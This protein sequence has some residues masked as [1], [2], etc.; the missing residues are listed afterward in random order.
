LNLGGVGKAFYIFFLLGTVM[1]IAN[2]EHTIR[3]SPGEQR[4]KIR[5]LVLG[6]GGLFVFFVFTSSQTLLFSQLNL[7]MLPVNSFVFLVCTILI[8]YS[9]VRHRLM[10]VN[11][12]MSR[13]IVYNSLTILVV[14]GYLIFVGLVTQ[15]VRSFD[16]LPG[17]H[18]E[19]LFLFLAIVVL[20]GLFL[21]DRI[22]WKARMFI[23]KHFYRS[24]YDYRE[25]WL[26][27]SEGLSL[28]LDINDLVPPIVSMLQETVAVKEVSLWLGD[29]NAGGLRPAGPD[30]SGEKGQLKLDQRFLEVLVEKKKPF[31]C[32]D[33]WAQSFFVDN[34]ELL[35]KFQPSLVVPMVSGREFCGLILLGEKTAGEPFLSDDI[36]LL[37]SAGSQIASAV[38]NAK[39][40]IELV[41]AR[42]ME[43]FHRISSFVLH[44]LKNLVS[45]LSLIVQ[46]AAE[47]MSNP[48]F[49]QDALETVGKSVKKMEALIARLSNNTG[50]LKLNPQET[51]LNQVVL[52]VAGRMA[53]NGLKNK[54]D[55]QT[56]L[57]NVPNV[58][59]D[60]EQIEK[61]I[62]NLV[63]NAFEAL[64]DGGS[65]TVKTEANGDNVILAVSDN[66]RGMS[67]DF[68][69]NALFKPFTSTKK[70]GLG[71]GLYQ[72]KTIV[73]AHH[74]RIEVESQEG[75]GSTFRVVLPASRKT[76]DRRR[77]T[78]D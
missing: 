53:Q 24:R 73:E 33:S 4:V 2:L 62:G 68:V 42:E 6:I 54:V 63:L 40:S 9:V 57:V 3:Q 30:S 47:H 69:A 31:S 13:F 70:K 18:L 46:N 60:R 52:E 61:V 10:D 74:G 51:D 50:D 75:K 41:E 7:R 76:A 14:G 49:Q 77:M 11:L 12:Y 43:T 59:A 28:K 22:R 78:A 72:C 34:S 29:S 45:N 36:D 5:P 32:E 25:E 64:D 67:P 55:M 35:K 39:L 1:V 16:L 56:D 66:G 27:F 21:S 71:I 37:R 48:E 19:I 38:M 65:V 44:D 20:L 23:N 26:K 58:L 17:Y 15:L 8:A